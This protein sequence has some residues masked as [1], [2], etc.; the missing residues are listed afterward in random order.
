MIRLRFRAS[1]VW[2]NEHHVPHAASVITNAQDKR[3]TVENNGSDV[4]LDHFHMIF[5]HV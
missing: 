4:L 2:Y 1:A 3:G 5:K